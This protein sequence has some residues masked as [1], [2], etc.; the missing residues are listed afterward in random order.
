MHRL[1]FLVTLVVA[2]SAWAQQTAAPPASASLSAQQIFA[3][4]CASCHGADLTG[5]RGPSLFAQSFL[6]ENS[7]EAILHTVETGIADGGMPSFKDQFSEDQIRQVIAY[8]RIR[9][10]QLKDHT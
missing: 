1:F 3:G 10:G 7:D 9:G 8:L 5:V 2:S 6:T 4:T